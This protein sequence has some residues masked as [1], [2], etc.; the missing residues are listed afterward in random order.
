MHR[1]TDFFN[2]EFVVKIQK[3]QQSKDKIEK[4][5]KSE[6][7]MLLSVNHPNV[8][9]LYD[10]FIFNNL[11]YYV[12]EKADGTLRDRLDPAKGVNFSLPEIVD[13]CCQILSGLSHIHQKQI[14]HR[15][16]QVRFSFV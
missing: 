7:K 13:I 12:L 9:Q 5:W 1:C 3:T 10:A 8:I 14:V 6:K 16:L 4:N 15:D 2:Q 11:Y